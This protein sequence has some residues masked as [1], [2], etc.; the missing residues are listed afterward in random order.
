MQIIGIQETI[1]FDWP[2]RAVTDA[3]TNRHGQKLCLV[4]A[5]LINEDNVRAVWQFVPDED[6]RPFAL[7]DEPADAIKSDRYWTVQAFAAAIKFTVKQV[8]HSWEDE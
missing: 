8:D 4:G 5:G 3:T 2:F 6:I 1:G 7:P